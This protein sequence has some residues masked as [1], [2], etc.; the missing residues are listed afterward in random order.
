MTS[1]NCTGAPL[2]WL[3]MEQYHLGEL[4][5]NERERV[6]RH[7]ADC[8]GCATCLD[9]IENSDIQLK[10]LPELPSGIWADFTGWFTRQWKLSV[11]VAALAAASAALL[12]IVGP[13]TTSQVTTIPPVSM[14]YKGGDL[15]IGLTRYRGNVAD[16]SPVRFV[17]GDAFSVQVTCPPIGVVS[18]DVTIFQG[19]DVFFP[20]DNSAQLSCG[21]RIPIE[22]AFTL[23][24]PHATT[25]CV[26]VDEAFERIAVK[27]N[28]I[29]ALPESTVCT[30][31]RP[32]E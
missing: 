2:S 15:A 23:S 17:D 7:L 18:W 26:T 4:P 30:T 31:V 24:G 13:F 27:K 25:V 22:G 32:V 8:P 3:V 9:S 20:F 11:G 29:S 28:G 14:S 12:I 6:R 16:D 5:Q 21:N 19:G 10:P 1:P